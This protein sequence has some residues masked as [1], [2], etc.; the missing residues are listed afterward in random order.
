MQ[1]E[2]EPEPEPEPRFTSAERRLRAVYAVH[3][4]DKLPSVPALLA[5]FAGRETELLGKVERKYLSRVAARDKTKAAHPGAVT[6]DSHPMRVSWVGGSRAAEQPCAERGRVGLC[7]CPG[8][9]MEKSRCVCQR[10]WLTVQMVC[11]RHCAIDR[12]GCERATRR[13]GSLSCVT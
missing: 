4:P 8:K 12:T 9:R 7:F 11:G 10:L 5:Q 1:P 3:A 6:S 2:P 13:A